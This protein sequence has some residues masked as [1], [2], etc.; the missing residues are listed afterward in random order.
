MNER[1]LFC[2][3]GIAA[4]G[5]CIFTTVDTIRLKMEHKVRGTVGILFCIAGI[6]LLSVILIGELI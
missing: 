1:V 5:F 6:L 3:I 4:L 2:I